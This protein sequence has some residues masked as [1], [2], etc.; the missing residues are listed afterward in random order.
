MADYDTHY[1]ERYAGLPDE[2]KEGYADS[3]VLSYC[4]K[5]ERPLF[6]VHGTAD[7]N[8]FFA[9]AAKV[10][11]CSHARMRLR[12]VAIKHSHLRCVR[13]SVP[14][15]ILCCAQ[16]SNALFRAGKTHDFLPLLEFTHMV[17]MRSRPD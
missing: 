10:L 14:R 16:M 9:H 11:A 12:V 1:T 3:N 8:V 7:D 4:D 13:L 15:L 6:I 2:N 5:L 17:I